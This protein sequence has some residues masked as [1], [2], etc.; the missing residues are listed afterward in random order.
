MCSLCLVTLTTSTRVA[1]RQI[2]VRVQSCYNVI[3]VFLLRPRVTEN[4]LVEDNRSHGASRSRC[5]LKSRNSQHAYAEDR[6]TLTAFTCVA[7]CVNITRVIT[8]VTV[9]KCSL[10]Q[11]NSTTAPFINRRRDVKLNNS[12]C[13]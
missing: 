1:L 6:I 2:F 13:H 5:S 8:E 9:L 12:Q 7:S 11:H 10:F 4:R 3:A